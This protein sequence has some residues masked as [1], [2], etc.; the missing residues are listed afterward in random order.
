MGYVFDW[1][2]F[3]NNNICTGVS[4]LTHGISSVTYDSCHF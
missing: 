4:C 1:F 2:C 3:N